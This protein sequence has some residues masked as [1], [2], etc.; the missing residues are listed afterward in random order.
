MRSALGAADGGRYERMR[1]STFVDEA[2][3]DVGGYEDRTSVTLRLTPGEAE[4]LR[5]ALADL[6]ARKEQ[7]D[8]GWHIRVESWDDTCEIV[9]LPDVE[10]ARDEPSREELLN[11]WLDEHAARDGGL[12]AAVNAVAESHNVDVARAKEILREHPA[13][14]ERL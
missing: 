6:L 9:L 2:K 4:N 7:D 3:G 12:M 5:I 8:D 1:I 13:W 10:G 14:R 11:R